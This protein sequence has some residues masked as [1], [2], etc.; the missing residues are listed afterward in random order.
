[1]IKLHLYYSV[2]MTRR[3]FSR[4]YLFFAGMLC[5]T[6]VTLLYKIGFSVME[7]QI[8]V[9]NAVTEDNDSGFHRVLSVVLCGLF[10]SITK[11]GKLFLHL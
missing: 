1:M 7:S 6:V 8:G 9:W 3:I 11:P 2:R 10:S 4:N 5:N